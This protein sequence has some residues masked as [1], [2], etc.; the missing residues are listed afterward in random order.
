MASTP[1][2]SGATEPVYAF[3]NG[4][5]GAP[6]TG[7]TDLFVR[8]RRDSDGQYFDFDDDTFKAAGHVEMDRLMTEV[9]A[10]LSPGLYRLSGGFDTGAITNAAAHDAYQVAIVQTGTT[11][12]LPPPRELRVGHE[13]DGL[14]ELVTSA[15][16]EST[17]PGTVRLIAWLSLD[18]APVTTGLTSCT[19]SLLDATGATVFGPSAMLG[20]NA[21][22]VFR[23]DV[24]GQS[25]VVAQQYFTKTILVTPDH[26]YTA[27]V[28]HPTVG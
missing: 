6:L 13:A 19:V 18:G 14:A 4:L 2:R 25:L 5:S 20:P 12:R 22:G 28:A 7:A 1:I 10:T 3:V 24:A 26:T 16:V 15:T 11:A 9:N 21:E 27:L 17:V 8:I 23:L